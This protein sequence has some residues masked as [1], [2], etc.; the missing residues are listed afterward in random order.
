MSV[1]KKDLKPSILLS[2]K[3][4][5]NSFIPTPDDRELM[6]DIRESLSYGKTVNLS[7]NHQFSFRFNPEYSWVFIT[8]Y[9]EGENPLRFGSK[10]DTLEEALNRVIDKLKKRDRYK[11][12]D[13]ADS[14]KVRIGFE[15]VTTPFE[16][17]N[18]IYGLSGGS[19]NSDRF[20]IGVDGLKI[21]SGDKVGFFMP[22][23]G[24][25]SN[26]LYLPDV[27]KWL[28]DRY[29]VKAR[30]CTFCKFKSRSFI[31][32]K[33]EV[34]GL[35]R[36]YPIKRIYTALDLRRAVVNGLD[37][38]IEHQQ[39]NGR[40]IYFADSITGDTKDYLYNRS[41][42]LK[43]V[44]MERYY[45]I[46]R[47]SG[48]LLCLLRGYEF[49]GKDEYLA[50]VERGLVYLSNTVRKRKTKNGEDAAYILF[51]KKAKLGG[52][53][54]A[55]VIFSRYQRITGDDKYYDL[56]KQLALHVLDEI[57]PDG[58]FNYYYMHPL[59]EKRSDSYFFS[60]YYPGEAL[61]GLAEFYNIC[62][63]NLLK[64]KIIKKSEQALDF[65]LFVRPKKYSSY[66]KSL[67][68][69][70]WLMSAILELT[71]ISQLNKGEYKQFV[72]SDAVK[73]IRHQY[74]FEN[75]LYPDYIGGFYYEYGNHMYP[76]GARS[77]G[78]FSAYELAKREGREVFKKLF[79]KRL[80]LAALCQLHLVNTSE[81]IYPCYNY[82][83][84][85]G[86]IRFKLTRQ[87]FRIDTIQHVA[88]F[89]MRLLRE[90]DANL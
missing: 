25:V 88:N 33:N 27:I 42:L 64:N 59:Q 84:A 37:W 24:Y 61:L 26:K 23:D 5:Y 31:T 32:F 51:N 21:E 43:E 44:G 7:Q 38:L 73:M 57:K 55:L 29:D 13:V 6:E 83:M 72:Y 19:L 70:S 48:A 45:N 77:E 86:G 12:F 2:D 50:A 39:D 74:I 17:I 76:D 56:A 46:L 79:L 81:S 90:I 60:F 9:Q 1:Q 85:L 87:W 54:L 71:N 20:E 40:F 75:T 65:L 82:N 66:Y 58:E 78:L 34:L 89:Y 80:K 35:Y 16:K 41:N 28:E 11:N 30:D 67:P 63:D 8:L 18:D 52:S 69:D 14:S 15:I 3:P 62:D 68:S 36:G 47:H 10:K 4:I 22:T 49:T 53:G